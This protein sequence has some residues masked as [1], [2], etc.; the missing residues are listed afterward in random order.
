MV[1]R[2]TDDVPEYVTRQDL[3]DAA[4]EAREEL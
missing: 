4:R 1:I 3:E 2:I